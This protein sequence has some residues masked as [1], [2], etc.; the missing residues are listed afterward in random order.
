L[1]IPAF[2][3]FTKTIFLTI[4]GIIPSRYNSKRFPGKPLATIN[5]KSMIQRVYEHAAK[6]GSLEKVIVATDDKRIFNHV[7]GFGGDVVMTSE[8]HQTGTERC[9]EVLSLMK[10][11]YGGVINIQGDEPFIQPEQ[12]ETVAKC[13]AE[14]AEI[15]TLV[16][17]IEKPEEFKSDS[18][19]KV[20][21]DKHRKALYFSRAPLPFVNRNQCWP[22]VPKNQKKS[23]SN[24]LHR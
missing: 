9:A 4:L 7:K 24:R 2:D 23:N 22:Y 5:G 20:V 18:V 11:N 14:G 1:F 19:V 21:V 3:N 16:K 12:I 10:G 6:A 13:L 15:A 17:R 8:E